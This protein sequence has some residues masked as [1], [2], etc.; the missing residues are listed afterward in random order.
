V[1]IQRRR[2][3]HAIDD[4]IS[5]HLQLALDSELGSDVDGK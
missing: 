4:R 2:D 5:L 3:V 1:E